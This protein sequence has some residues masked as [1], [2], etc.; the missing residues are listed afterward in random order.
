MVVG[1]DIRCLQDTWRTG[2]G[3]VAWQTLRALAN[4]P[5]IKLVGFANAAGKINLPPEVEKVIKVVRTRVPNKVKNL[6]FYLKLGKSLDKLLTEQSGTPIDVL[7]LPNPG[8]AFFSGQVPVVLTVHDLSFIHFSEFF[9]RR[10]KWWYF[11]AVRQLLKKGLPQKS[12]VAAVSQHTADDLVEQ[13]PNL[14]SKIKVIYPGVTEDNFTSPSDQFK[15]SVRDKFNLPTRFLL[16]VGT[17]EP[18][19][20]YGLL[21]QAYDNLL[22]IEPTYPWDLV[23]V[24]GWGW[25]SQALKKQY[26]NLTCQSRI[27]FVGYVTSEEKKALYAQAELFLYPSFYEGFGIP[28]LEAMAASVPVVVSHTSSLADVVG[29]GGVLLNPR[30]SSA[31]VEALQWLKEDAGARQQ[32]SQQGRRQAQ[33]FS[34]TS[35]A[36]SYYDLFKSLLN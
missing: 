6:A 36:Q 20:N 33:K 29:E 19:K 1:V 31:W 24:G 25:R 4:F 34:W 13:F 23:I 17:V 16:S 5:D 11:P 15:K 3:E 21:L 30:K 27:H 28:P 35:S 32:L 8:F 14:R 12:F 9:P 22:K 18:R 7:W 10:G 26:N 2:V